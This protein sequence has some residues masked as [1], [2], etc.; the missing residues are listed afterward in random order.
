[1]PGIIAKSV[2]FHENF[3]GIGLVTDTEIITRSVLAADKI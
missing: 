3:S 2:G 1:M